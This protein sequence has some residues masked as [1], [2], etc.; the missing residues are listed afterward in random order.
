MK[1]MILVLGIAV[2]VVACSKDDNSGTSAVVETITV[3]DV[4][5]DTIIGITPGA[6]P[7]GGFPYGAGRY[8]FYSLETNKIVP[9]SDSAS[10]KWDLA[11]KG[12]TIATNSG[13]SGPGG[14]GA[15]WADRRRSNV[16]KAQSAGPCG[17]G[18]PT[19][20]NDPGPP[21]RTEPRP[22]DPPPPLV[23]RGRG[24]TR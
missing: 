19:T 24:P 23:H 3:R 20:G 16:A 12:T 6:P 13:N 10:N 1:Q 11:F 5:A 21:P 9:A 22:P 2:S 8:T 7:T 17:E 4:P 15:S 14:A 18:A